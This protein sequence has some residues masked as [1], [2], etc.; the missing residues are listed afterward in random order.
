MGRAVC[1]GAERWRERQ[2]D[3]RQCVHSGKSY[4]GDVAQYTT[5]QALSVRHHCILVSSGSP[6]HAHDPSMSC[7][8]RF[9]W[10]CALASWPGPC[11]M[12]TAIV[13]RWHVQGYGRATGRERLLT[14][15]SDCFPPR[16]G[17]GSW[18]I[19]R[20][21]PRFMA[22]AAARAVEGTGCMLLWYV[23]RFSHVTATITD[24]TLAWHMHGRAGKVDAMQVA[25]Q[26]TVA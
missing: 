23:A 21:W 13:L 2:R 4:C 20:L 16:P 10:P 18:V 14:G 11:C 12:L 17:G 5:G 8:V 7:T 19:L 26:P 15:L 3:I 9:F 1:G 24:L 22:V 25:G 6:P